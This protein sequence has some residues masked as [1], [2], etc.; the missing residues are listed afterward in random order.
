MKPNQQLSGCC[1]RFRRYGP[2]FALIA[3]GLSYY[4]AYASLF[5][6]NLQDEG[7]LLY[8]A[9]AFSQGQMPYQDVRLFT[10][11]PG[12]FYLFT[13]VMKFSGPGVY[14]PRVV[15]LA[16][17]SVTPWLLYRT[18]LRFAGKWL[19][20]GVALVV[21]LVPGP[22][23]KFY[24]GLIG[25]ASIYCCLGM[26]TAPSATWG[27]AMGMVL[28]GAFLIR[29]DTAVAA[30]GLLVVA[31]A[32]GKWSSDSSKSFSW[33]PYLWVA[34]GATLILA[35][36]AVWLADV[37]GLW[38]HCRQWLNFF[39]L[40]LARTTSADKTPGPSIADLLGLDHA[41]ADA[42]LFYGSLVPVALLAAMCLMKAVRRP[43]PGP[44][45]LDVAAL[46]LVLFWSLTSL[47][48][49]FL[50]RPDV[51]HLTQRAF[52]FFLP[53]AVVLQKSVDWS[54][55]GTRGLSRIV[56]M[57]PAAFLCIY[58]VAFVVKHEALGQG[59]SAGIIR[60][61]V[62]WH[63]LS[64]GMSFPEASGSRTGELLQYLVGNSDSNDRIAALPYLPGV[65]FL[66]QRLMPTREVY[67]LP[68]SMGPEIE[69][70]LIAALNRRPVPFVVYA[71]R[72]AINPGRSNLPENFASRVHGYLRLN[73]EKVME[74]DGIELLARRG[75]QR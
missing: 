54:R 37:G 19:A 68:Q 66:A 69:T 30:L 56:G 73:F 57:L 9:Y 72:Q 75:N 13:A 41:A 26:L 48:Q 44:E 4:A 35:P 3:G 52:S 59:G 1:D 47:P 63:K 65:N 14:W 58:S 33:K 61:P 70:D 74:S 50:E 2:D 38:E 62:T 23:H 55:R 6:F 40:V 39:P 18:A 42:W 45:R 71:P 29:M 12:L 36:W 21:L 16:G 60:T 10:Y 17:L 51:P 22:W 64:N 7:Y 67:L 43:V 34:A 15:M 46:G 31:A 49:Y 11:L 5:P 24:V 20:F 28:A 8:I 27:A 32:L 53:L 25:V